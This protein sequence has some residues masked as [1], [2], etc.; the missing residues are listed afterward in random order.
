M[1]ST[2]SPHDGSYIFLPLL[3]STSSLGLRH[4]S[5]RHSVSLS[6]NSVFQS[7]PE[8]SKLTTIVAV[9]QNLG[10]SWS[11]NPSHFYAKPWSPCPGRLSAAEIIQV[12]CLAT[13]KHMFLFSPPMGLQQIAQ[14]ASAIR[15]AYVRN[16]LHTATSPQ[17]AV[18]TVWSSWPKVAKCHLWIYKTA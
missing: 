18:L 11:F 10:F 6:P 17:N 3:V 2:T 4:W 16:V 9:C 15:L 1:E 12:I 5:P 7:A 13:A 14:L 8:R